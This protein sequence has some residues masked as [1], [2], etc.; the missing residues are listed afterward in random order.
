MKVSDDQSMFAWGLKRFPRGLGWDHSGCLKELEFGPKEQEADGFS[1]GPL[2]STSP[3][4]FENSWNIIP[5]KRSTINRGAPH[6]MTNRGLRIDI[7]FLE[8]EVMLLDPN[9]SPSAWSKSLSYVALGCVEEGNPYCPLT[10]CVIHLEGN[11]YARALGAYAT[12][13][14]VA[15]PIYMDKPLRSVYLL[16]QPQSYTTGAPSKHLTETACLLRKLPEDFGPCQDAYPP[17]CWNQEK[18]TISVTHGP[19]WM[20]LIFPLADRNAEGIALVLN[21]KPPIWYCNL[22]M[23]SLDD[24][25][26]RKSSSY[27]IDK[28]PPLRENGAAYEVNTAGKVYRIRVTEDLVLGAVS[29]LEVEDITKTKL[30]AS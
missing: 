2:L 1:A 29:Q 12:A 22:E 30:K 6:A 14:A 5:S 26:E 9:L 23:V 27:T 7:H 10:M 19:E 17:G 15:W 4:Y 13:A 25:A 16:Q 11:I 28:L 20:V 8:N 24:S 3:A 21:C 18:G